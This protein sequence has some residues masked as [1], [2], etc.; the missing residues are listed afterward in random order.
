MAEEPSF[1]GDQGLTI[2]NCGAGGVVSVAVSIEGLASAVGGAETEA[3]TGPVVG[4][5]YDIG[6]EFIGEPMFAAYPVG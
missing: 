3:S 6:D 2:G 1:L 4:D 5:E